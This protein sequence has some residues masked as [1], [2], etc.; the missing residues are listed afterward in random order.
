MSFCVKRSDIAQH[1]RKPN[2]NGCAATRIRKPPQKVTGESRERIVTILRQ[3]PETERRAGQSGGMRD[4]KLA[5]YVEQQDKI[6]MPASAAPSG[7]VSSSGGQT[8]TDGTGTSGSVGGGVTANPSAGISTDPA[9]A[10]RTAHAGLPA[11]IPRPAT[12]AIAGAPS[13]RPS[14]HSRQRIPR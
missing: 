6:D 14:K 9:P 11:P 12:V 5:M 3:R 7:E 13:Y 10:G 1:G 2:C 8:S 4:V